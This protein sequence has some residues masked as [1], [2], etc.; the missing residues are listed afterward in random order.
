MNINTEFGHDFHQRGGDEW[1]YGLVLKCAEIKGLEALREMFG[2]ANNNFK[3]HETV[4]NLGIRYDLGKD[5]TMLASGGRSFHSASDQPDL[6][7]YG[8][9]Q[10]RFGK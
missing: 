6:L 10:F 9:F 7:L 8:G 5:Y 2:T 1:I 3:K 4:F